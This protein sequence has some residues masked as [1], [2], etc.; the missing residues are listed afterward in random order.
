MQASKLFNRLRFKLATC[1]AGLYCVS[2]TSINADSYHDNSIELIQSDA[3][4]LKPTMR[5]LFNKL[6]LGTGVLGM[7]PI[8]LTALFKPRSLL[9]WLVSIPFSSF[10]GYQLW[11]LITGCSAFLTR[12]TLHPDTMTVDLYRELQV[13]D[14]VP[15]KL[16]APVSSL[17][18]Y[19][20]HYLYLP[21]TGSIKETAEAYNIM[22]D[23]FILSNMTLRVLI[24]RSTSDDFAYMG[25]PEATLNDWCSD[26]YVRKDLMFAVMSGDVD[27]VKL[28]TDDDRDK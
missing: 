5:Q 1:T 3:N 27:R 11:R 13:F 9:C 10:I 25:L 18:M 21:P 28:L 7:G 24:S 2:Q 12:A 23:Q 8:V 19:N 4:S 16:T 17:C 14:L 22:R 26:R 20:E 15:R 6:A